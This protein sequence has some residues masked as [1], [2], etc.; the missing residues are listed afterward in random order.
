MDGHPPDKPGDGRIEH[1]FAF[2]PARQHRIGHKRGRI[3]RSRFAN[4]DE[5][6]ATEVDRRV[7]ECVRRM[8]EE[9]LH[10][11]AANKRALRLPV[12][13]SKHGP[14]GGIEL[15]RNAADHVQFRAT[16]RKALGEHTQWVSHWSGQ[17]GI[18]PLN[19]C[20][21]HPALAFALPSQFEPGIVGIVE[22]SAVPCSNVCLG[23]ES[24][25]ALRRRT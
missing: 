7:P 19:G 6:P 18:D 13:I 23:S 11:R 12:K 24:N 14:Q 15:L 22:D 25:H 2:E 10:E 4:V 16:K 9:P 20:V 21:P 8:P 3:A 1:Q 17:L 5:F